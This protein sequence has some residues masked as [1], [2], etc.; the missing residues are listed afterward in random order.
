MSRARLDEFVDELSK[1]YED[2]DVY[3]AETNLS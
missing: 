2:L 3:T 1:V